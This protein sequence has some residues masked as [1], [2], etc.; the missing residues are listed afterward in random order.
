VGTAEALPLDD[1][2]F[3]HVLLLRSWNHLRDPRRALARIVDVTVPGATVLLVDNVACGLARTAAQ[4][5]RAESS[6]AV[7][8][9]FRNDAAAAAQ[10]AAAGLP[11]RP[12]EAREVGPETSTEWLVRFERF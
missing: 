12:V 2:R 7:F 9:H 6:P 4:A 11:L 3:D 8:E 1:T 5:S 10:R